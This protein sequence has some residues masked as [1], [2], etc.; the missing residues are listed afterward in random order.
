MFIIIQLSCITLILFYLYELYHSLD[1]IQ[2]LGLLIGAFLQ[3]LII[4]T[5]LPNK[6]NK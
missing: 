6:E 2:M 4:L 1:S 5:S 3:L